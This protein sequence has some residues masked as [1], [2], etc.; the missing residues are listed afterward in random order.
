MILTNGLGAPLDGPLDVTS[1]I[2]WAGFANSKLHT[3]IEPLLTNYLREL[4]G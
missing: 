1:G 2:S 3:L 4:G